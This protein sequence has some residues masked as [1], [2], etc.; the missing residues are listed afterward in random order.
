[1]YSTILISPSKHQHDDHDQSNQLRNLM[2]KE[3]GKLSMIR[4]ALCQQNTSRL[5]LQP[6]ASLLLQNAAPK[7]TSILSNFTNDDTTRHEGT[8]KLLVEDHAAQ[9]STLATK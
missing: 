8:E 9:I 7:I 4:K 5:V 3:L 1:M 6:S 2:P